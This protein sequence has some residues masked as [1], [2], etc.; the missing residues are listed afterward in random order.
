MAELCGLP[1]VN[2]RDGYAEGDELIRMSARVVQDAALACGGTACRYGGPRLA[3]LVPECDEAGTRAVAARLQET[4]PVD[5]SARI[6]FAVRRP[7][8]PGVK[9]VER[10]RVALRPPV[11]EVHAS[12]AQQRARW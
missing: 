3:L 11:V 2:A 4:L 1:L 12:P 7:A 10:A 9:V 6:A 8:E 5:A